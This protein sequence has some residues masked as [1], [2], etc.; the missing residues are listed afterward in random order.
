MDDLKVFATFRRMVERQVNRF[1]AI[2]IVL[3]VFGL[4]FGL[5]GNRAE[6]A[7]SGLFTATAQAAP[8][9]V[10]QKPAT[11]TRP[12]IVLILADDLG[13]GELGCYGQARIKTP[14]L[15]KMAEEG[16]RF[17][18]AY[19]GSTVC[20]PSRCALMTGLHTGHARI[21]GNASVALAP[22]DT[23][24][25]TMLKNAGYHTGLVGKWGLGSQNTTGV[26]WKQGFDE[27]IGY[28][29]QVQAHNY[30]PENLWRFDPANNFEG[31]VSF[32][33]NA[34]GAKKMYS[35]DLF[36]K[37]ALNFIRINKPTFVNK[38][39]PFFLFLA[40]TIP[41]ANNEEG[42]RTGNGME[43]PS[44]A[45]YS[46]EPWPDPEKGKAAMITRMDQDV[47]RLMRLLKELQIDD[48]TIVFFA[49]DNGP[50]KEGGATPEFFR[51]SG[52]LRGYKRDLYD[53]GI[54]VPM[55]AHWPGMVKAGQVSQEPW[56]FWDF[57]ATAAEI[58]GI[59]NAPPTDGIS[60][61]PTLFGKT[62]TNRHEFFYWEFH[63]RGF[64]QAVRMGDWK[65]I[66]SAGKPFELYNLA[67]DIGEQTNVAEQ[68]KD[69]A[70]RIK[71]YLKTA[72]TD[73]AQWP[74]TKTEGNSQK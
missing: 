60:I 35:H 64:Q 26:P 13:Y 45:P 65:G 74:A 25:A 40:Y 62:Q 18:Q 23:T 38:Y 28:L 44:T 1:A 9:N 69:V 57:M 12:N 4:G 55:I 50:H 70:D 48:N 63:E 24:V 21:R 54:R 68:H 41:H 67:S 36:T 8:G 5:P 47:G 16:M 71:A 59:T 17:T 66:S 73:S 14:N 42:K 32:P 29:G 27:Y 58:A 10:F 31:Q 2:A 15:D 30:Y 46:D 33:E 61:A 20:A 19:A 11:G 7:G 34:D 56:A 53:G 6:Q 39:R 43:V 52:P 49:S 37:S 22:E 51:S 72:R 3:L